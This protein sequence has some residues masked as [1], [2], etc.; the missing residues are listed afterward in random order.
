MPE[1]KIYKRKN[2]KTKMTRQSNL[3]QKVYTNAIEF[4]LFWPSAAGH[5]P[6]LMQVI[7]PCLTPL[8]KV[9]FSFVSGY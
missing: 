6:T 5:E 8:E 4:I 1:T 7:Y 2:N 3:R 9:K